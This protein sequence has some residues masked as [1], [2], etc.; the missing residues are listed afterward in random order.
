MTKGLHG[1]PG[2]PEP[3][4]ESFDRWRELLRAEAERHEP[5]EA[6]LWARVES[7]MDDPDAPV[8]DERGPEHRRRRVGLRVGAAVLATAA[9]TVAGSVIA[10][11]LAEPDHTPVAPLA[12]SD[13]RLSRPPVAGRTGP[14]GQT[15][16]SGSPSLAPGS[17]S[18]ATPGASASS[19]PTTSSTRGGEKSG[20]KGGG[21]D[22]I[23]AVT[24]AVDPQSSAYWAQHNVTLRVPQ[25]LERLTVTIR[26]VRTEKVAA[27]GSWL[28][29]PNDDFESSTQVSGNSLV[30][31]WTLRAGRSVRPG[32]YTLA[33]QYNRGADHNPR[34]DTFTVSATA[35]AAT[36]DRNQTVTGHF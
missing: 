10:V 25:N 8:T 16:P 29:L 28:S 23:L 27:A 19:S 18:G 33:A 22:D 12:Q 17:T 3:P 2:K 35:P 1:E 36:G 11:K 14:G 6:D 24:A 7:A 21:N 26:I 9:A 34:Q 32:T 31:R 30:Y 5:A 13:G 4:D 15:S 20:Q